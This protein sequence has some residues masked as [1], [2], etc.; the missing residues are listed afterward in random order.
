MNRNPSH[1]LI[2]DQAGKEIY[3][4]CAITTFCAKNLILR[5]SFRRGKYFSD[6]TVIIAILSTLMHTG[7][8]KDNIETP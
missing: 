2:N 3:L 1:F 7:Q 4:Y 5:V 8:I 6:I